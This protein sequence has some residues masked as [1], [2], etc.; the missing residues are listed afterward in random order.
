MAGDR[1]NLPVAAPGGVEPVA[2]AL[3]LDGCA[4]CDR[5]QP[6]TQLGLSF[7]HCHYYS[8]SSVAK[9]KYSPRATHSRGKQ[10]PQAGI[11]NYSTGQ[12]SPPVAMGL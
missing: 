11:K 12:V 6:I 8:G 5:L 2:A 9:S 10:T 1:A 3:H 4:L 7:L